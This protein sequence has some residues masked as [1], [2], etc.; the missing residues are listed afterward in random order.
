[1]S[2]DEKEILNLDPWMIAMD[3][4]ARFYDGSS[5]KWHR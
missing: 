5:R 1:M 3:A 4:L 2:Y